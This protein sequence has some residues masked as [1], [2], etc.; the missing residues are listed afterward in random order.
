ML[1]ISAQYTSWYYGTKET[2]NIIEIPNYKILLSKEEFEKKHIIN[3]MV[4]SSFVIDSTI[5]ETVAGKN[6][7]GVLVRHKGG[8]VSQEVSK[9]E[10]QDKSYLKEL[11]VW[12]GGIDTIQNKVFYKICELDKVF[13]VEEKNISLEYEILGD[14]K[15][16]TDAINRYISMSREDQEA[17]FEYTKRFVCYDLFTEKQNEY[18]QYLN[19]YKEMGIMVENMGLYDN[20]GVSTGLSFNVTNLSNKTIKYIEIGVTGLNAVR[21]KVIEKGKSVQLAKCIGPIYSYHTASY[22]FK[23]LWWTDLVEYYRVN[24]YI[25]TYMDG[26]NKKIKE[27]EDPRQNFLMETL[28][29]DMNFLPDLKKYVY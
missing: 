17:Y 23:Y 22:D 3:Y 24:Y 4:N 28:K 12:F 15:D 14:I 9:G 16:A 13:Y 10:L 6:Y 5:V 25:I 2:M 19:K 20:N 8:Y 1:D 27:N 7:N 18:S 21:D 26:T 29:D 11:V